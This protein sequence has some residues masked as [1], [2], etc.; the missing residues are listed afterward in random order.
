MTNEEM[1]VLY[2]ELKEYILSGDFSESE[3]EGVARVLRELADWFLN[4]K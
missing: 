2:M 1:D 4:G 3:K